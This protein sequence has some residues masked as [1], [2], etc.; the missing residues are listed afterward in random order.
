M[1]ILHENIT[2]LR[3][4]GQ[5][6]AELF[7]TLGLYQVKDLLTYYPRAYEDRTVFKKI[8]ELRDGE[9]VCI[10]ARAV[11]SVRENRIRKNMTVTTLKVS[12][13][14]AY[15]ELVWFNNRFIK[16]M[17]ALDKEYIFYG[18]VTLSGKRQMHTPL[19]ELPG[20]NKL[21]GNI[22]P[23]YGL[24]A[25]LTSKI[26]SETV[27]QALEQTAEFLPDPL[28][29]WI[30]KHYQLCSKSYAIRNIHFPK[31]DEAL[32]IARRRLA[33]EELLVFQSALLY[34]RGNR[35]KHNST[36]LPETDC[37]SD[38]IATLPFPLTGAQSRVIGE[39]CEDLKR[40]VPMSRLVQGD[41]GCGKTMIAACAMYICYQNGQAS[42][43][44]APTEILATQHYE[45]LTELF[46]PFGIEVRLITGSMTAK[47]RR[48]VTEEIESGKVKIIV[49]THALISEKTI[50]G[51]PALIITD[52]QHRFGVAQRKSLEEKGTH[53]HTLV[54]TATPIPRTLA[55]IL[56][57]DLDVSI[58]DELPPGRKK[59]DTFVLGE[60]MRQ[61]INAFIQKE[62]DAGRQVYIVCPAVEPS[63]TPGIKDVTTH[64]EELK[65]LFGS[66]NV[67]MIHGKMKPQEK[68]EIMGRFKNGDI[69]ILV[70]TSVIE[71]GVN[72]PNAS[73]MVIENAARFGLSQ[74][75]QLRGRVGRGSDKAYCILFP[76]ENTP[77]DNPRMATMKQYSDGF[78]I[79]E[80]D[81]KLRG[82]GEFFGPRQSGLFCF[83]IANIF[84]DA[85]ILAETT[86]C[87]KKLLDSDPELKQA[88]NQAISDAILSL[89]DTNI[90]FS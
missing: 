60:D 16:N 21:T 90:T 20:A 55:L 54:M 40:D 22:V 30:L 27:A 74:L 58:I 69:K 18:K 83:R 47:Q 3:G 14:T 66:D 68:D 36:P 39:I 80:A 76:G 73:V 62:T 23:V 12:D 88:E 1:D 24:C 11:S 7:R 31:D 52:E 29:D 34:L 48:E 32:R 4:I 53:P 50:L 59:I 17:I 61:R 42:A 71:V 78:Q 5:K 67:S 6:R 49:G 19:F 81:L 25:G 77:P 45:S 84:C 28:P 86:A 89:F 56:Y 26:V 44:M 72:V 41:V 13:G 46:A 75:H 85:D 63:E 70:A 37:V 79:A 43:M 2:A 51:N 35:L 87:S 33:F 64:T 65:K 82:P 57:G 10:R 15:L 9:T 8:L 38:F